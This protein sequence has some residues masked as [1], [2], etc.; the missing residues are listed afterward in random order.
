MRGFVGRPDASRCHRRKA[1]GQKSAV[2]GSEG[3]RAIQQMEKTIKRL[4]LPETDSVEELA[5]FWDN[6]DL[7]D[8]AHDLQE[9]SE[10]V[11]VRAKG[12]SL[13]IELP[14]AEAQH[15][16]KIAR[17]KGVQ[18]TTVLRDWILERLHGFS[19]VRRAPNKGLQ[20]T[21]LKPRRG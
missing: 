15:L 17:S 16:K 4:R 21:A 9:V 6:H 14:P 7:T 18:E 8:F 13:S 1:H 12:T 3:K 11:F 5:R 19:S 10:P 20:S 2:R